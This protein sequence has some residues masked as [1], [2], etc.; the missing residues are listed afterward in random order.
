MASTAKRMLVL[1]NVN[2]TY[3]IGDD[4]EWASAE[5]QDYAAFNQQ[6]LQKLYTQLTHIPEK[7]QLLTAFI[8]T[9]WQPINMQG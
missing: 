2:L 8:N 6:E 5:V 4:R 3:H 1:R 9:Y 7:Q